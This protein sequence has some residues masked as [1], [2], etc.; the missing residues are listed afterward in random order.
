MFSILHSTLQ[1][2]S[3][4][5]M[6]KLTYKTLWVKD[7]CTTYTVWQIEL[8]GVRVRPTATVLL[9]VPNDITLTAAHSFPDGTGLITSSK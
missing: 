8:S 5:S 4:F 3:K 1:E 7:R 9:Q 2:P 6:T